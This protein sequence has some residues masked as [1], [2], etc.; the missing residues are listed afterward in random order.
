MNTV[1]LPDFQQTKALT[2]AG[3]VALRMSE[4][5]AS[6]TS[7]AVWLA[8]GRYRNQNVAIQ[9]IISVLKYSSSG[10]QELV[11]LVKLKVHYRYWTL[12]EAILIQ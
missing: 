11:S 1:S 7:S 10:C 5:K 3:V 8:S 4:M 9:R 6:V 2:K 12:F